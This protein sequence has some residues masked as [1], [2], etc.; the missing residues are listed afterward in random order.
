MYIKIIV[1]IVLGFNIFLYGL[2]NNVYFGEI[3]NSVVLSLICIGLSLYILN[4]LKIKKIN[5]EK[6]FMINILY[7]SVLTIIYKPCI[8]LLTSILTE[9]IQTRRNSKSYTFF[10]ILIYFI[11][12]IK[13]K[14]DYMLISLGILSIIF[15][16]ES[17][18]V[19]LKKENVEKL[20]FDLK[21]KIYTIEESRK[22]ENKLN[23]QHQEVIKIEERNILSQKLHDKIGHTIVGS[24]MQLEALKII[25]NSDIDKSKFILDKIC[26]NLRNGMDDIRTTLRKTKPIQSE[27][28]I[29]N[30]RL[31]L[32]EFSKE[33]K[34]KN[35][36]DI[37]GDMKEINI[38]YWKVILNSINEILTNTIKYSNADLITV[39]ISVLNKI[40][41]IHI[42]DNGNVCKNIEKG[43]GLIGIEERVINSGGNVY[44]NNEDGFSTLI[45]FN[46]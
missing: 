11:I 17:I 45:I 33:Y 8:L 13:I 20:N 10:M 18:N 39:N 44:F 30:L 34:I 41:R 22:L 28:G 26:D 15:I 42:K 46:R 21:Q 35:K 43:L 38:I 5:K 19:E 3:N 16:Y 6:M 24:I 40:I 29:E 12:V 9:Y 4:N 31:I 7:M 23:Y 1:N 14:L 37:E 27:L 25:M 2:D 32:D 36:I